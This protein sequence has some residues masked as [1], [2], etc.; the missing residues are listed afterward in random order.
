MKN[1]RGMGI[2]QTII[3]VIIIAIIV[4]MGV[5]FARM[6]YKEARLQT[7][8]TDMLQ[9]Q[10]KVK[11]YMD[12]RTAEKQETSYIGVKI[13]DAMDDPI[14]QEFL[15]KNIISEEEYE[16]YY[17]L[18]DQDLEA[19]GVEITNYEGC[20]FIVNYDNYEIIITQG[21]EYKENETIYKLSEIE[22]LSNIESK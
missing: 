18:K 7:I 10:W 2:I 22:K 8:K 1:N 11:D 19:A 3:F 17:I 9:V 16:K 13:T 14:V 6:K 15:A 21:F 12:K 20:Y 4:A 5:Y